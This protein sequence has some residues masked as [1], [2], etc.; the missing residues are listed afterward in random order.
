MWSE[1]KEFI[2]KGNVFDLAVG[3]IIGGAFGKIVSSMVDDLLLP[4]IG[5]VLGGVDFAS[6]KIVLGTKLEGDKTIEIALRYGS[7]IQHLID[8][9]LL[10]FVVFLLVRAYNRMRAATPPPAPPATEVLLTE[11]RDALKAQIGT[12]V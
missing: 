1:F 2:S 10:A 9:T 3:V 8:F 7:F 12:G 6:A 4:L 5:K 11:I